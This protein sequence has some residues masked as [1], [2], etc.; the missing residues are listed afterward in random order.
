VTFPAF[1]PERR[2]TLT[3]TE[4]LIGRSSRSRGIEPAI[5]LTGPP[6][7][8]GVSHAHAL[9]VPGADGGWSV[10]DLHSPN[11]AYLN[12]PPDPLPPNQPTP[13]S[14]GDRIHVGAWTTLT[15]M[16]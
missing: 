8:A 6:E 16:T 12:H 2:F 11:G 15:V 9:F 7:D 4:V 10:V 13:L 5:D 1:C 14:V 3:G